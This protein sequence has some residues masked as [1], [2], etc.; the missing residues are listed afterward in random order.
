MANIDIYNGKEKLYTEEE[1]DRRM[2]AMFPRRSKL[3]YREK[4]EKVI[5]KMNEEYHY[6]YEEYL[7]FS[8]NKLIL[9]DIGLIKRKKK[10]FLD[11]KIKELERL[12]EYSELSSS[13]ILDIILDSMNDS[14]TYEVIIYNQIDREETKQLIVNNKA[15]INQS[16]ISI[17]DESTKQSIRDQSTVASSVNECF[18]VVEEKWIKREYYDINYFPNINYL[19]KIYFK[20][21]KYFAYNYPNDTQTYCFT[22][23]KS[24]SKDD[25]IGII[26]K[27]K[28]FKEEY[29]LCF[30]GKKINECNKICK[31]GEMMCRECMEE[32][33]KLYKLDKN[34]LINIHGRVC[35]RLNDNKYYCLG[36]I[37][38]NYKTVKLCSSSFMCNSCK[39]INKYLDYYN[40][41]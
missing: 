41:K 38:D 15:N 31:T 4:R 18:S 16:Q 36:K 6:N 22:Q 39:L 12:P 25:Y 23:S 14:E 40:I 30:C 11:G 29:G 17:L 5:Q 21:D 1:I 24:F 8:N 10:E 35:K 34:I 9:F 26:N 19:P 37:E 33:K 2:K 3:T 13:Q 20:Y 27:S 32:T 28:N 7:D